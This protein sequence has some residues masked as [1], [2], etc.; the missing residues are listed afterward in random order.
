[1]SYLNY[2]EKDKKIK[3][4]APRIDSFD[5]L[6]ANMTNDFRTTTINQ[7]TQAV[8]DVIYFLK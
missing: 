5:V 3:E 1:M 4:D 7:N 8:D 2:D 6:A